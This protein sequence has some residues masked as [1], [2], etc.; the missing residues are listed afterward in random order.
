MG[1]PQKSSI[2][3]GFSWIFHY[4]PFIRGTKILKSKAETSIL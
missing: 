2:L 4:K 3:M 1:I